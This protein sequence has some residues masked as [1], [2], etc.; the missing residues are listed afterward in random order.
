LAFVTWPE[1]PALS[2][3][4]PLILIHVE[5]PTAFSGRG[6]V[7]TVE[8]TDDVAALKVA[9]RIADETGKRVTVRLADMTIIGTIPAASNH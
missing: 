4:S 8:M 2:G 7:I 6:S 1:G 9:Q 3:K 5:N